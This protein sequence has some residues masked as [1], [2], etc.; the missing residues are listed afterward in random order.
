MSRAEFYYPWL[1]YD[2][3][4]LVTVSKRISGLHW[5][6]PIFATF[7]PLYSSSHAKKEDVSNRDVPLCINDS[8]TRLEP[9]AQRS[10]LIQFM[11]SESWPF[12]NSPSSETI[13]VLTST[14]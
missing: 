5:T 2:K 1:L 7:E 13:D 9:V 6:S 8:A 14:S 4:S 10:V 12:S 3:S 11:P